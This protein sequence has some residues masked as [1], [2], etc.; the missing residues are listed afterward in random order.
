MSDM[1]RLTKR[2]GYGI[3]GNNATVKNYPL[4]KVALEDPL[5][6]GIVGQCFEKLAHYEDLAEQ[7]RL[8]VLPCNVGGKL[9]QPFI[10]EGCIVEFVLIGIVYDI[11]LKKWHLEVAYEIGHNFRK[12]IREI[13]NIGKTVFLTKAEAEAKLKAQEGM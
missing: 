11:V 4:Y 5:D 12:T 8:I 6:H 1:E 2:T 13:E 9:F 7:G 10:N 3:C